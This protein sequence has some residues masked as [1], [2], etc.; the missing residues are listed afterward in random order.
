MNKII[1]SGNLGKEPELRFIAGSGKAVCNF[2][3]AVKR[4]FSDQS[5]WFNIVTWGK[6]AENCANYLSKGSKVLVGGYS[7]QESWEKDD[8]TKGYKQVVN[9]TTVEFLIKVD[10]SNQQPQNNFDN[11]GFQSIE[12]DDEIPF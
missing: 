2:S 4:P 11:Q 10:K 7:Y 12:D 9:A 3:I 6:T 5:D 8:G 1:L